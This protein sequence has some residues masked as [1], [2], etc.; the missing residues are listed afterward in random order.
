[1]YQFDEHFDFR[2]KRIMMQLSSKAAN[3]TP[4]GMQREQI[5]FMFTNQSTEK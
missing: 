1:M 5:G 3:S 2:S 4:N